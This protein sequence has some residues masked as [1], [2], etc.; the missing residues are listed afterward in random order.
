M[1]SLENLSDEYNTAIDIVLKK[2]ERQKVPFILAGERNF[3]F[4][5]FYSISLCSISINSIV[6]DIL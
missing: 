6:P 2:A 5:I 3:L 4:I 1:R